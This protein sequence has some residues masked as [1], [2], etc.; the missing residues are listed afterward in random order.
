MSSG[1]RRGIS[2]SHRHSRERGNPAVLRP[3]CRKEKAG[4]PLAR[5]RRKLVGVKH[6]ARLRAR[7]RS[8]SFLVAV[9]LAAPFLG[10]AS[11]LAFFSSPRLF[12]SAAIRSMTLEP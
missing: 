11:A 12:F 8:G 4:P 6:Y 3:H 1:A 2:A 5:G 10:L 7:A 9:F